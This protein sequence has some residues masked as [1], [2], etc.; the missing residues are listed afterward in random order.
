MNAE[1]V[2]I[3]SEMLGADKVDTNSLF[4]TAR[5]NELG[6][7]V[8]QKC[9][10]GDDRARLTAYI[11]EAMRRS[12]IVIVTGGLGPTEDDV[13]RDAVA[14]ACGCQLV[15]HQ[16]LCDDIAARFRSM[17]KTMAGNNKRQAFLIDGAEA[18]PNDRGTAPGQWVTHEGRHIVLLPGPPKELKAMYELQCASRFAKLLP[19]QVIRTLLYR[20]A[21]MGE[22][23]LDNLIAPVYTRYLNPACTILAAAGDI[24]IHLRARCG[25]TSEADALL[26]EVATQIEPLLGDYLYTRTGENLEAAVGRLLGAAGSTVAV[27]ESLTGGA[28]GARFT[29]VP[30]SS[31][32]FLGGFLTYSDAMK[33]ALLGVDARLLERETAVSQA[34]AEA[35]AVGVR[36]RTGSTWGLSVTGYAGPDT[37]GL[38]TGTVYIGIAH[39]SGMEAE[40]FHF[41]GDRDR[42]RTLSTQY[43]LDTLRRR[44]SRDRKGL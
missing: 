13:T 34:V 2:A 14:A 44:L 5:L 18:L 36:E 6:V 31:A 29:S 7:E 15:F 24:Q 1:I 42:V 32:Y 9:V 43:A 41:L 23:D 33:T 28:L 19:P 11:A 4:L 20:V 16:G 35:M 10:I 25:T 22:S 39:K 8:V 12:E 37:E 27:A 3:G 40:R 38:P 17:K 26:N 21:G 30:G